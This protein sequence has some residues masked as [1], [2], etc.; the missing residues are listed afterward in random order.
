MVAGAFD[1]L[2][3]DA[4]R[5]LLAGVRDLAAGPARR[6]VT[7]VVFTR[8]G[9]YA[10]LLD[11][12]R[13]DWRERRLHLAWS[14]R[15]LRAAAG[16]RLARA[17]N[18]RSAAGADGIALQRFFMDAARG[19]WVGG[20]PS[21]GLVW[22]RT[23]ARP[24]DMVFFLRAVARC[25]CHRGRGRVDAEALRL[26][27]LSYAAYLRQDVADEIRDLAPDVDELLAAIARYGTR[28]MSA[29]EL[30][31]LVERVL[32][33]SGEG[34]AGARATIERFF[35]AS[36]IGN[37]TPVV[38]RGGRERFREVFIHDDPE[39]TLDYTAPVVVH[40]GLAS[41]LGLDVELAA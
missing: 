8:P 31:E 20:N 34:V 2:R 29:Q 17:R 18:P 25:A 13:A 26:G 16:R 14:S 5:V 30:V 38:G 11:Q 22:S 40:P 19:G 37:W 39:A 15:E 21:W 1:A 10:R 12:D 24:R 4:L 7:P 32:A 28:R 36:A 33:Q 23:R 35:E 41:A 6:G 3:V 27:E 9:L